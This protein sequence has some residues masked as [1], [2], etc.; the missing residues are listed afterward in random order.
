[1]KAFYENRTYDL[2]IPLSISRTRDLD[3]VAHWHRDIELVYVC[4]GS[5]G[6]GINSEYRILAAGDM[7]VCRSNDIHYYDSKGRTSSIILL[8]FRPELLFPVKQRPEGLQPASAFFGGISGVS[9]DRIPAILSD[10]VEEWKQKQDLYSS[11]IRLQM[12]ELFLTLFRCVPSYYRDSLANGTASEAPEDI[13]PM[14]KALLYLEENYA[15]EISLEQISNEVNL[16]RYYFSR[17]FLKTTGM[18][19]HAYLNRIRTDKAEELIRS[20]KKP[21]LEIAYETGFI[22]IRTFNRMF[23]AIKGCN[24]KS[25]RP[26]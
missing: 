15:Q 10:I 2:E 5:I 13:K 17:L 8:I 25:M 16:S 6:V 24:P 19:F 3:F 14:Q 7:A 23:K 1:M 21:I 9:R 11:F 18:N 4:E 20:T 12:T 26:L 22:S